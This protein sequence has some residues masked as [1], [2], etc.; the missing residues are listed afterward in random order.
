M[1]DAEAT[2]KFAVVDAITMNWDPS[3]DPVK[4]GEAVTAAVLEE[5]R[6]GSPTS[7]AF[8]EVSKEPAS[9]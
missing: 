9:E 8:R 5:V 7:W 4:F 3:G 6:T 2:V 1:S